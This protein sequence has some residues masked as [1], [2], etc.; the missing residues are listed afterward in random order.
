MCISVYR[1]M[2]MSENVESEKI[3]FVVTKAGLNAQL[4][5]NE[6]N[7]KLSLSRVVLGAGQYV[8]T[9]DRTALAAPFTE[10]GISAGGI[11]INSFTLRMMLI[12]NYQLEKQVSEIGLYTST[13]VL[14]AVAS[15]P[16]GGFF[17]LYPGIDY[18]ANFGLVLNAVGAEN[19]DIVLDGRGGIATQ[20][21]QQH[22]LQEDPHP[23]YK[24]YAGQLLTQHVN[25]PDPHA[26]YALK[27]FLKDET[28]KLD[29]QIG[30][31]LGLTDFLFP[32]LLQ[33]GYASTETVMAERRKG[34]NYTWS[35]RSIV[36]HFC[37]EA[38]HEGWSTIRETTR[39]TTKVTNR[40][41]T[42]NIAYNGHSDYVI[43]DTERTLLKRGFVAKT[44]Q[45]ANEIKSGVFEAGEKLTI[46]RE[47]WESLAYNTNDVVLLLTPEGT[48]EGWEVTRT[49]DSFNINIWARSGTNRIAYNGRVNWSLFK[50]NNAPLQRDKYPFN[51]ITGI[52]SG[53]SFLI[54]APE[55]HDFTD[56]T[57]LPIITPEGS[58]EAWT[59][60]RQKDGFKVEV[61]GRSGTNTIGYSGRVNWAVFITT[62]PVQRTVFYKG[63]HKIEVPP[64]K[65]VDFAMYAGGGGGGG[66][67]YTP[68]TIW[69]NGTNAQDTVLTLGTT[70]F[71]A[72]GGKGGTGGAWGNGSHYFNG[73]AGEGGE[74]IIEN[75]TTGFTV[76]KNVDGN[77]AV[78]TTRWE[79]Q[80][81]AVATSFDSGLD[82]TNAG[83]AGSWGIGQEKWSYGGSGGSGG[84]LLV[85]YTNYGLETVVFDLVVGD[86]GKGHT[87]WGLSGDDGGPSFVILSR[88]V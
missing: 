35:G 64:G 62:K 74:N 71:T 24:I 19:I 87:G 53:S 58:H 15:K 54:P 55:G 59:I 70:K 57:Y 75:L 31:L 28:K 41:G 17:R 45:L 12:M 20:L 51:L 25:E 78:I 66:S 27:S 37:P 63:T 49:A 69:A 5:A 44:N 48:H 43:I 61:F 7:I 67:A 84:Y 6:K 60:T 29:N 32:P 23:Q 42:N 46:T 26:Q 56:P 10:N 3:D 86:S 76:L 52:A 72:G 9:P 11:E 88:E 14:F 36:Y 65:T 38:K 18:V 83:G 16:N 73:A 2:C 22:T 39:I 68:V 4:D 80:I 21:M 82:V 8:P 81:G 33:A 1:V 77:D 34:A 79:R 30:L 40:S 13:G 85:E 47:G 50:A